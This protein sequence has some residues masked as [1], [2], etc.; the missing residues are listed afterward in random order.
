MTSL[1]DQMIVAIAKA[2]AD[3]D[4][5]AT[6]D[7]VLKEQ[8]RDE[9]G[10]FAGG[11][12]ATDLADRVARVGATSSNGVVLPKDSSRSVDNEFAKPRGTAFAAE[13]DELS[14]KH[15]ETAQA[16]QEKVN[17]AIGT[18]KD[19]TALQD[20]AD[21]HEAASDAHDAAAIA[22]RTYS[23]DRTQDD[24][25]HDASRAAA[26]ASRIADAMTSLVTD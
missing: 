5:R 26:R 17:D 18:K 15:L 19:T 4:L 16:L 11:G 3:A 25:H 14:A 22:A 20:A 10:R 9:R 8:E 24:A 1:T 21:A 13:H 12:S 7:S 6:I 2:R 23:R